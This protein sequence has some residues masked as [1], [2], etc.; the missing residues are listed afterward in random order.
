MGV[1]GS[2]DKIIAQESKKVKRMFQ[3]SFL[4]MK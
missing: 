3:I 2:F 1:I 4:K